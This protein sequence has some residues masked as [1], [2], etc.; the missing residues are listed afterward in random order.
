MNIC[1]YIGNIEIKITEK[2]VLSFLKIIKRWPLNYPWGQSSVEIINNY[3]NNINTFFNSDGFLNYDEWYKYYN[4]GYTTI[5]SDV[6]D[7]NDQLRKINMD[8]KYKIGNEVNA[9]LY[10]SKSKQLASF[11]PHSHSYP[12]IVKQIYG[13]CH[14]KINNKKVTINPQ[15]TFYIPAETIH[16]VESSKEKRLS[17]TINLK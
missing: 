14:W 8:L 9:N 1:K 2:E 4:K 17:L 11:K 5:L 12:V 16:S 10:F 13:Q 7:L 6:L 3:N 15:D